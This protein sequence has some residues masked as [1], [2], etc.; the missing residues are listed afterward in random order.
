[1]CVMRKSHLVHLFCVRNKIFIIFYLF[2][3]FS[4][5]FSLSFSLSPFVFCLCW[6]RFKTR[7]NSAKMGK[8]LI[9]QQ[10]KKINVYGLLFEH[11]SIWQKEQS[12]YWVTP[13]FL[14]LSHAKAS[15]MKLK[16]RDTLYISAPPCKQP[17]PHPNHALKKNYHLKQKT[18]KKHKKCE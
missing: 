5:H 12:E 11:K 15:C 7:A 18:K 4:P 9:W 17:P 16:E 2:V 14:S 3:L 13:H 1:M 8:R 10:Q 6:T